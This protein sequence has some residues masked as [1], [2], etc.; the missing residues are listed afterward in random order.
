MVK[1]ERIDCVRT[2]R[3]PRH[4]FDRQRTH[5]K[6]IAKIA[7]HAPGSSQDLTDP[8]IAA[9]CAPATIAMERRTPGSACAKQSYAEVASQA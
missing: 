8:M 9:H 5:P 7:P 6:A 1:F 3:P 4:H 2:F